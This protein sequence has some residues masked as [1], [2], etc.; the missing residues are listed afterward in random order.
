MQ[1]LTP[2]LLLAAYAEGYF[3]MAPSRHVKDINWYSPDPRAIIPLDGFHVPRS[4]AKLVKKAPFTVT[5]DKDFRRVINA[6]AERKAT[7]INDEIT[8]L[9]CQL[10]RMGF[11]HSIECWQGDELAGGLYGVTLG[12]AFFGESMFTRIENASRIALVHLV[13]MLN[14]KGYQLLDTQFVNDHLLQF[15]VVEIGRDE[16]L[17]RLDEAVHTPPLAEWA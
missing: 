1:E 8:E 16:Y 3:P 12:S 17:E 9:Y 14:A 2:E 5:T 13:A 4:L 15:G 11:A 6:C 10:H 7:W